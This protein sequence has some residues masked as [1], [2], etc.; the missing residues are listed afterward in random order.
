MVKRVAY[1][2]MFLAHL[3]DQL[4]IK[5]V[6]R[7]V[8]HEPLTNL[9]K[10]IFVQCAQGMPRTEV[11]RALRGAST[12][13]ADCGKICIAVSEDID[14]TNADAVFWSLA[15]RSNPIDDVHVVPYRSAGPWAEVRHAQRGIHAADRRHAEGDRAAARAAGAR[16]HGARAAIWEEL[17]LPRASPRSRHGTAIR[18]ATGPTTRA[19]TTRARGRFSR[20]PTTTATTRCG[21]RAAVTAP[22]GWPRR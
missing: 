7:V 19:T 16:I 10:V 6:R 20:S 3:R 21:S 1:E 4:S 8:M 13:L 15:Y 14:P 9:R 18:W 11:W 12:L 2:P 17:K 5:G 22:A